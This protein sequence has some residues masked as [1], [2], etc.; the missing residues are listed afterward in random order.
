LDTW[1]SDLDIPLG[2]DSLFGAREVLSMVVLPGVNNSLA[3][4]FMKTGLSPPYLGTAVFDNATV[5]SSITP[6]HDGAYYLTIGPDASTLYGGD[7]EGTFYALR[8]TS[9]G[10][11]T[12][13][14]VSGLLG[15]DGSPV[16]QAGLFYDGWGDAIDPT[17]PRVVRTYDNAGLVLPLPDLSRV[18]ILG[19]VT[20]PGYVGF[21]SPTLTLN[22]AS[23]GAR[24]WSLPLP[25][26]IGINHGPMIGWGSNGVAMRESQVY[27]N[28]PAPSIDLMRLDLTD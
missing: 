23:K 4:S 22:D 14:T 15:G 3:V 9:G 18:L 2:Q 17:I 8:V 1:V 5:R 20:P 11:T 10:V 19:G 27:P 25:V 24:L 28:D 26:Q 7:N 21:S 13:S 12:A 6:G 16:Y